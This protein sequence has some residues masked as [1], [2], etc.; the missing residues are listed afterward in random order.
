MCSMHCEHVIKGL[1][2]YT[3]MRMCVCQAAHVQVRG[4]FSPSTTLLSQ[5]WVIRC[6]SK[7]VYLLRHLAHPKLNFCFYYF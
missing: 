2:F 7:R 4:Q 6:D 5:A 1:N 3:Y